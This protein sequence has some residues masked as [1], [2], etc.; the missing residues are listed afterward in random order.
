VR[1]LYDMQNGFRR[2]PG[3]DLM[4]P[5]VARLTEADMIAIAAYAAS[6]NP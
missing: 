3:S 4:K 6:R 1:Q 5:T 2:G